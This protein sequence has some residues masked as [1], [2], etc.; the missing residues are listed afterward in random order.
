MIYPV[1]SYKD[2]MIGFGTPT[3]NINDNVAMRDFR[4]AMK[5]NAHAGDY[6]LYKI[7]MY[8]TD[9]GVLTSDITFLLRGE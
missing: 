3:L 5:N 4:E 6:A 8:D 1:Y 2:E 7:G 9:T